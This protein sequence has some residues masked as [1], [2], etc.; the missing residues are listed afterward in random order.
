MGSLAVLGIGTFLALALIAKVLSGIESLTY[1]R[2]IVII[3]AVTAGAL[4][5]SRQPLLPYLD[6]TVLGIGLVTAC[7]RLGCL[8][9]GCCHGR[10]ARWG[11]RYRREHAQ[12]GFPEYLVGVPLIPIQAIESIAVLAIVALATLS[13]AA[14]SQ[15]GEALTSYVVSYGAVRFLLE[16]ARGDTDRAYLLGFSEAQWT[17]LTLVA[18]VV[19]GESIG[20]FARH[21]E[22]TVVG[23]CLVTA[24]LVVTATRARDDQ[25][26]FAI[27]H[28]QHVRELAEALRRVAQAGGAIPAADGRSRPSEITVARTSVGVRLSTAVLR[29]PATTR[30][31]W[32]LSS[33][34]GTLNEAGARRLAT[35]IGQL[36]GVGD[37]WQMV[38]GREG[39][40]HMILNAP[41]QEP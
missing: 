34:E 20:I 2:H 24:I 12:A 29:T 7:G 15:A 22:H 38:G 23:I 9:V 8:L 33:D 16:F 1:Y 25:R 39:I 28:P 31:L 41:L 30:R 40:F 19:A 27:T 14:G 11:V 3:L 36:Q 10:P 6:L 5:I 26:R 32:T 13:V 21:P 4:T 37:K 18:S 17:S 35:V